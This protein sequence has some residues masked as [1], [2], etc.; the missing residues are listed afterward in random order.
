[1]LSVHLL[2][3]ICSVSISDSYYWNVSPSCDVTQRLLFI[4]VRSRLSLIDIKDISLRGELTIENF[5]ELFKQLIC[6]DIFY[7]CL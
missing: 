3:H 7:S 6:Y 2:S 1:M 4:I 5:F